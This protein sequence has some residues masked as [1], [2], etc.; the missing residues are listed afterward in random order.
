MS[1]TFPHFY[2]KTGKNLRRAATLAIDGNVRAAATKL[3]DHKLLSKL[4]AGDMHAQDAY[5]HASCLTALYNR[6]RNIRPL[7]EEGDKD[8]SQVSL[9]AIALAE[10][11]MYIEEAPRPMV[12][13]LSDLAKMYSSSLERLG[14]HVP[15]RINSTRLK[16]RLLAQIPELSTYTEGKEVKLAFSS[17]IGAAL[18]FAKT[19]DHDAEAMYLAKAAMLVRK[20]LFSKKQCFNGAFDAHSQ[21]SKVP[22]LLL[23]LVNMILE[24]PNVK[25]KIEQETM[26]MSTGVL[27]SQLLTFN[28]VKRHRDPNSDATATRHDPHRE[29]P[30][31]VYLGLLVHA[32]TRKKMLVDKLY[33]LG[34]SISYDRV[35]QISA[36]LG[37]GVIAQYEE[38]GVVCPSKLKKSLFTTGSVD[39]IDHNTSSRIAKDSF[40]GTA[41]SLT[42]HPTN[43]LEGIGRN[44]V[45]INDDIPKRKT[46]SNLPDAYT[47]IEPY[48]EQ[49]AKKDYYVPGGCN[50]NKPKSD[51][52]SENLK[53]E[54]QWLNKV[55]EL[56]DKEK[57]EEKEYLSWSAHLPPYKSDL[58]RPLQ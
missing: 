32:V 46:V 44:R 50:A 21:R 9:E 30:V 42:E 11:V 51:L 16:D 22:E 23:A 34:L 31:P 41:I 12:F 28:A 25:N 48:L 40:H 7:K 17:D 39:N 6:V 43:D 8:I 3:Q 19:H 45:L 57:L 13:Q 35:M 14:A 49:Q 15:D 56:L 20:E 27:I 47:V 1:S 33:R 4:A 53:C 54:Y 24:G 58:P 29:P 2:V 5:Y 55:E 37:N 36:D 38:E 26:S 52:V 18:N 10:L